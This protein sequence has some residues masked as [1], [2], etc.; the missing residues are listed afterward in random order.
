MK[1]GAW[2]IA[3]R[4][5]GNNL[6]GKTERGKLTGFSIRGGASRAGI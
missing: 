3:V 5:V 1:K 6:R 4:N 2:L